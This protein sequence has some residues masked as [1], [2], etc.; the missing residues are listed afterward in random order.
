MAAMSRVGGVAAAGFMGLSLA[1]VGKSGGFNFVR[2][3]RVSFK[4]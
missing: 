1:A 2:A 3:N 4:K